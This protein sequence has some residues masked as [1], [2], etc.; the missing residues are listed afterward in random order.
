MDYRWYED[1]DE[2]EYDDHYDWYDLAGEDQYREETS[3]PT[4]F[5]LLNFWFL[6]SLFFDLGEWDLF[7]D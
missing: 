5:D 7:P 3:E 2:E 1:K 6:G 4:H